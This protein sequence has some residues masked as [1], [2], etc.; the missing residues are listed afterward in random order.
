LNYLPW[1]T[2]CT[3]YWTLWIYLKRLYDALPTK[4]MTT[5][6]TTFLFNLTIANSTDLTTLF[7]LFSG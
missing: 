1:K 2:L 3:A 6:R 7:R 4:R 5:L